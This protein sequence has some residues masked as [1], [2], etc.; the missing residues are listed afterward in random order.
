MSA[1]PTATFSLVCPLGFFLHLDL[2]ESALCLLYTELTIQLRG[3]FTA[4]SAASCLESKRAASRALAP[5][6][7]LQPLLLA[8]LLHGPRVLTLSVLL[9]RCHALASP[10]MRTCG[11]CRRPVTPAAAQTF[12]LCT[13]SPG[14]QGCALQGQGLAGE[15]T[16]APLDVSPLVLSAW[17]V[18]PA[19]HRPDGTLAPPQLLRSPLLILLPRG[20]HLCRVALGFPCALP[21]S[22]PRCPCVAAPVS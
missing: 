11:R 10:L 17:R 7:P 20:P 8:P 21:G 19:A 13:D 6:A 1:V 9:T 2:C 14:A 22:G 4:E 12:V 5:A 18:P 16:S 3:A 15:L